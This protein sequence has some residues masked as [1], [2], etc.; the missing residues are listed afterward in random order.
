MGKTAETVIVR[1][2]AYFSRFPPQFSPCENCAPIVQT[3]LWNY[4]RPCS[5]SPYRTSFLPTLCLHLYPQLRKLPLFS[6]SHTSRS[7][8]RSFRPAKTA[9]SLFKQ[10]YGTFLP[11]F[12]PSPYRT[13]FFTYIT[14]DPLSTAAE[15][16]AVLSFA[17]FSQF[18]P[19]FSPRKLRTHCSN[20]AMEFYIPCSA[21]PYRTSFSTYIIFA[22]LSIAVRP[23]LTYSRMPNGSRSFI[24]LSILSSLPVASTITESTSTSTMCAR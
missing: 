21:P 12:R 4:I 20:N 23:V 19:Q 15:T 13:S 16:S 9:H 3:T 7:F 5:A 10:R 17:Y 8:R 6:H 18:P 24:K 22:P 2:F 14:L 11:L 1:S